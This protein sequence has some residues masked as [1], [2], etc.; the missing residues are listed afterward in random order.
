M[1]AIKMIPREEY[2]LWLPKKRMAAWVIIKN[3][4]WQILVLKTSYKET[5]EIPWWVTEKWESPAECA[6]R[7]VLEEIWVHIEVW[8]L[9][10]LEYL[11]TD[12]DDCL[13]FLFDWGILKSDDIIIDNKEIV[14]ARFVHKEKIAEYISHSG[15][16]KRI[17]K[18]FS[19]KVNWP[20]YY[21]S[22]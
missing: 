13:M 15:L 1:T 9:L 2:L 10:V 14:E 21:E 12:I 19:W 7:E 22:L 17:K 8:N 20:Q 5:W 18:A 16:L 3:T 6:K 11:K 4:Q